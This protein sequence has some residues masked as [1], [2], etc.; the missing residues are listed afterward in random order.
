MPSSKTDTAVRFPQSA[1]Q[2]P[3]IRNVTQNRK[4]AARAQDQADSAASKLQQPTLT[5]NQLL[6]E[7]MDA[8][9]DPVPEPVTNG[10][11]SRAAQNETDVYEAMTEKYD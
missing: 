9:G 7:H 11:G 5:P 6:S 3:R 1:D 10:R 2:Q 8:S 4:A